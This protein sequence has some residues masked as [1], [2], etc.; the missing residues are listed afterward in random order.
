MDILF[1]NVNTSQVTYVDLRKF[2][3]LFKIKLRLGV[4]NVQQW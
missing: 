3:F 4:Y 1:L 2:E